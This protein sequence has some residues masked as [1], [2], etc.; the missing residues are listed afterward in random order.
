MAD[1]IGII[2]YALD[3]MHGGIGRYSRELIR[4]VGQALPR[5]H[6]LAAGKFEAQY[7]TVQLPGSALLPAL[8]TL[9]QVEIAWA[10]R[11]H[12]LDIVHDPT[13]IFPL[14]LTSSRKVV[15]IHDVFSYVSP[16]TSTAADR[17]IYRLWLPLA[18]RRTDAVITVSLQS[19]KDILRYLP[20]RA[21]MMT[22]IPE[23]A[24]SN[25]Q[26][27]PR[28]NVETILKKNGIDFPYILYVGSVEPRKNLLRLLKAYARVRESLSGR[29][30]VVVGARNIWLSTPLTEEIRRLNIEPWVHFTGYVEDE[31]LPAFYNG[32]DVFVFPSLYEGFGLPVLEAM[33]CGTPVITSNVSSLPEVAGDAAVL[34]DPY[35]IEGIASAM[36]QV[37]EDP[38]LS[39]ELREKG[40]A[41]AKQFSWERTARETIAVYKRVMEGS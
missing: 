6:I 12:H 38:H 25:F 35:N 14:A 8:M 18:V 4:S 22:V 3:R 13:G 21:D 39:N 30:L 36:Q 7:P 33:G 20:V 28:V 34:V 24:G 1:S 17:L 32:A 41:R 15:S 40:L 26:P 23:A 9:G 37:L 19:K 10:A 5:M 31:D 16:E 2:A 27:M 29:K 11:Q